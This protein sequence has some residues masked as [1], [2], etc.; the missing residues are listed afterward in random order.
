MKK[1]FLILSMLPFF[2]LSCVVSKKK[3]EELE[4]AKR[5]SDAKVVALDSENSKKSTQIT[6]LN[7]K[8]DQTLAEYNEMKNSMSESNAMKNT[9]IDDLSTELMGLASDTTE[10]KVKLMETLDKYNSA[11]NLN[12]ENNLKISGLLKQIE[13]LKLESGKLSQD[14]KTASVEADWEKKKIETETQKNR[15]L[16]SM[17]DKE[18]ESL[19]A[20]IKEKDGK[21]SWLRKVKDENEAEIEKLTNQVKLYK[22]EYEKAV[23]K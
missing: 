12:E 22:K 10:L 13:G 18:I 8:L 4:Y 19:K 16:I 14:L 1:Q 3:Y 9:E 11:L 6:E 20:E 21:L 2:L 15:D 7:S 5:R 23:A 17:K